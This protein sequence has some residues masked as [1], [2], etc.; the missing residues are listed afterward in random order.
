MFSI[1]RRYK[2]E[3]KKDGKGREWEKKERK[4]EEERR[5]RGNKKK[6]EIIKKKKPTRYAF[7]FEIRFLRVK[8]TKSNHGPNRET[9]RR[10]VSFLKRTRAPFLFFHVW[11]GCA[12]TYMFSSSFLSAKLLSPE[13]LFF[14]HYSCF[15]SCFPP[16]P[17]AP[18]TYTFACAMACFCLPN[19]VVS[20]LE[21][22]FFFLYGCG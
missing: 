14:P 16:Q 4:K 8:S 18:S 1:V 10:E 5:I 19:F 7:S 20:S 11:R 3:V 6:R 13:Y 9:E 12:S 15:L 17:T 22:W 2:K 21:G